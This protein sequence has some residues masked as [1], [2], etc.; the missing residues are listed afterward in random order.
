MWRVPERMKVE[1]GQEEETTTKTIQE[2]F[3]KTKRYKFSH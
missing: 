3:L 1:N 2:H